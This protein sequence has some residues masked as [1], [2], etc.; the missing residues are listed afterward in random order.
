MSRYG[1]AKREAERLVLSQGGKVIRFGLIVDTKKSGG[2]YLEL[3]EVFNKMPFLFLPHPSYFP[4]GITTLDEFISRVKCLLVEKE[5]VVNNFMAPVEWTN[6]NSLAR[7]STNKKIITIPA[8]FTLAICKIIRV[9]PLGK[10]DNL[11]GIAFK[12]L[13]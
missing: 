4:I 3:L 8:V 6:L 1:L 7:K 10:I 5:T 13:S 9:L 12:A 11:K 2:R